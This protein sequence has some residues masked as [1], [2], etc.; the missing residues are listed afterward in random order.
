MTVQVTVEFSEIVFSALRQTPTDFVREMRLAAAIKRTLSSPVRT[1]AGESAV[2]TWARRHPG[3]EV[4]LD[5]RAARKC[6]E[7]WACSCW[8]NARS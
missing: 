2:L 6:A 4:I 7:Y 5:S 8:Q 1:C 3:Y